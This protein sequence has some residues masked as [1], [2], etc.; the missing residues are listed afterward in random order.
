MVAHV[1]MRVAFL[2][3]LWLLRSSWALEGCELART[4]NDLLLSLIAEVILSGLT[5]AQFRCVV[6]HAFLHNR[7]LFQGDFL[8]IFHIFNILITR[9]RDRFC[10]GQLLVRCVDAKTDRWHLLLM[11][12]LVIWYE[13]LLFA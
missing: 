7:L 3:D 10:E 4:A 5:T 12:A 11:N 2:K 8:R 6:D 9:G 13:C 1:K